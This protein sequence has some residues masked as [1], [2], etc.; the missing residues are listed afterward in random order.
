ML[1]SRLSDI[2]PLSHA[3]VVTQLSGVALACYP[4]APQGSYAWLVVCAA[5]AML[6]VATLFFNR[7]GNFSVYPEIKREAVLITGGP[8]RFVRHPMYCALLTMMIG[9]AIFNGGLSNVLGALLVAAAVVAKA[10]REEQLLRTRFPDY[11]QYA[12]V[13]GRFFPRLRRTL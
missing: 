13:T 12:A 8:Y 9:I 10:L 1:S 4:T 11:A 6:G 3:L 2:R 5:G 7:P